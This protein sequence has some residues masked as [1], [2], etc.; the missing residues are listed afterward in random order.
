M[1]SDLKQIKKPIESDL[2]AFNTYFNNIFKSNIP[3]LDRILKY[4]VKTKGKQVRPLFVTLTAGICGEIGEKT[5]RAASLIELLH[6]ATL[7]H[8]DVVDDSLKRRGLFSINALWKNKIAVLAGDF[9]L[10]RG[11]LLAIENND[12]DTLE[13]TSRAVKRMS[14]GELL[15]IEK[16]RSLDIR[17][18]VYFEIIGMKTASLI[19]SSLAAGA[20]SSGANSEVVET[21][22]KIGENIGIAFQIRDDLLDFS[23]NN[24]GKPKGGDIKEKK[25]TLPLI[26]AL[27]KADKKEKRHIINTISR[28]KNHKKTYKLVVKFIEKHKGFEYAREK[29]LEYKN[30]SISMLDAFPDSAY[31][32]SLKQLINYVID[33]KK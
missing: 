13:V 14:E 32:T 19:S 30:E 16:A 1:S 24:I 7:V 21:F 10:S 9:L 15:Q 22:S 28:S 11:L 5:Y 12:I 2:S 29:M 3:L 8:D 17:E 25:L 18:E 31:K 23:D 20:I 27:N 6:T 33:R 26:F 4:I